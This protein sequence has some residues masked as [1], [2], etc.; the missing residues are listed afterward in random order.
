M[1]IQVTKNSYNDPSTECIV[2]ILQNL[3]IEIQHTDFIMNGVM[4]NL[5]NDKSNNKSL[6]LLSNKFNK[7]VTSSDKFNIP[8]PVLLGFYKFSSHRTPTNLELEDFCPYGLYCPYKT[9]PLMCPLNHH[10]MPNKIF[11]GMNVPTLLCRYELYKITGEK[12]FCTNPY[13][14]YNHTKGRA[15]RIKMGCYHRY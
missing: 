9:H 10:E 1:S 3:D 4:R 6:L 12:M 8:L 14:W 15:I 7:S 13:C 2:R 5:P 11:R